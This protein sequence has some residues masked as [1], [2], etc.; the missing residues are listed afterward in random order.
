MIENLF[1]I[2]TYMIFTNQENTLATAVKYALK[3][4]GS[5]FHNQEYWVKKAIHIASKENIVASQV[6]IPDIIECIQ[7]GHVDLAAYLYSKTQVKERV[8]T[9]FDNF[10]QLTKAEYHNNIELQKLHT[11]ILGIGY[12]TFETLS[13]FLVT[14]GISENALSNHGTADLI[15]LLLSNASFEFKAEDPAMTEKLEKIEQIIG[16]GPS[17]NGSVELF[18]IFNSIIPVRDFSGLID[19]LGI[20]QPSFGKFNIDV[21]CENGKPSIMASLKINENNLV[22]KELANLG[23]STGGIHVGT[24]DLPIHSPVDITLGVEQDGALS[25]EAGLD[26]PGGSAVSTAVKAIGQAV[27]NHHDA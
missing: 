1:K 6:P 5:L 23:K 13:V 22:G 15:K 9:L 2:I 14:K 18:K 27:D 21:K 7:N 19:E 17:A 25:V 10:M 24:D 3:P 20:H 16:Q 26:V 12:R 11:E 4:K 8:Q